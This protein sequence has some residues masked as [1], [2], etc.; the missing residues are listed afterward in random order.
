MTTV[1]DL[2][3]RVSQVQKCEPFQLILGLNREINGSKVLNK[4]FLNILLGKKHRVNA[5]R[6]KI[7]CQNDTMPLR[8]W[9]SKIIRI[10][11]AR[12]SREQ[13]HVCKRNDDGFNSAEHCDPV[14]K[15]SVVRA[16]CDGMVTCNVTVDESTM[17]DHCPTVF[18]YLNVLYD[19]SKSFSYFTN[20]QL[21]G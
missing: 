16:L 17:G 20:N 8:C 2:I 12:Y 11:A 6:T 3:H 19:C 14:F 21:N 9:S 18:K 1:W 5:I 10:Y 15:T 7:A 13:D 4:R